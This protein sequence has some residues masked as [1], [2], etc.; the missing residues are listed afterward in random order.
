MGAIDNAVCDAVLNAMNGNGTFTAAVAPI[1]LRLG[2]T[3][4]TGSSDMTEL[5]NGGG[6]TTGG[7]EIGMNSAASNQATGPT[8]TITWVNSSGS[9]WSIVG[10]E[11]WDSSGSPRRMFYG[12]WS[13]QPISVPNGYAFQVPIG[14]VVTGLT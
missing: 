5:P 12:T 3:A 9:A 4:P 13:G 11:T 6:Y 10:G 14:N 2:S 1:N 8:S 7:A